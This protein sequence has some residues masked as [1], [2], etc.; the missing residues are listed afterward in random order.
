MT[1]L[2]E[3]TLSL[4]MFLLAFAATPL[5]RA[6]DDAPKPPATRPA[7]QS[8]R[9]W[10]PAKAGEAYEMKVSAAEMTDSGQGDGAADPDE[11]LGV[12]LEARVTVLEAD[13]AGNAT[14]LTYTVK[15]AVRVAGGKESELL[16]AGRVVTVTVDQGGDTQFALDQ[17]DVSDEMR[18][19][20]E[21]AT[22]LP[23]GDT[24]LDDIFGT[25]DA[26]RQPGG[27]WPAN[28]GQAVNDYR[29]DGPNYAKAEVSGRAKV[30]G[31]EKLD[32]ASHRKVTADLEVKFSD[33]LTQPADRPEGLDFVASGT[34]VMVKAWLP[35]VESDD[36]A[37][38]M[39]SQSWTSTTTYKGRPGTAD[40]DATATVTTRGASE[41]RVRKVK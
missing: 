12:Q 24:V 41:V 37:T 6:A 4:I 18:D 20:L 27:A 11:S 25:D 5:T 16:P 26:P 32:G 9:F 22:L 14:K 39:R 29:P 15:R 38:V 33:P 31:E 40:A 21:L 30:V 23:N 35:A 3:R 19:A 28:H 13:E 7:G 1:R 10:Q 17:G 34:K 36:S 2:T 8:V